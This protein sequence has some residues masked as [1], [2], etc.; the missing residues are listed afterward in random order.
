VKYRVDE[1]VTFVVPGRAH[2]VLIAR[3]HVQVRKVSQWSA[4]YYGWLVRA[5]WRW[6]HSE[7]WFSLLPSKRFVSANPALRE[8]LSLRREMSWTERSLADVRRTYGISFEVV[9][10]A[11]GQRNPKNEVWR[12]WLRA[13]T[14]D[15]ICRVCLT[16]RLPQLRRAFFVLPERYAVP[17]P[18]SLNEVDEFRDSVPG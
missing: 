4:E 8:R 6:R 17:H 12:A 2:T 1:W 3:P 10:E 7:D 9:A 11:L 15:C 18:I 14:R 13:I 16:A 5:F